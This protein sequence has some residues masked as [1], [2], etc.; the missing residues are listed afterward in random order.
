[1]SKTHTQRYAQTIRPTKNLVV[2]THL[3]GAEWYP[4]SV[5]KLQKL[6]IFKVMIDLGTL[7]RRFVSLITKVLWVTLMSHDTTRTGFERTP[8]AGV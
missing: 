4:E 6:L 5:T 1:M 3:P 7:P 8:H 2:F